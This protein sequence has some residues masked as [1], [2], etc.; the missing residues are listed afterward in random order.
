MITGKDKGKT[1]KIS[2]AFP[3]KNLVL[4]AGVNVKKR[5]QKARRS[6]Q[7]GQVL[8][9]ASPIHI[10]NVMIVEE[11]KRGRVGMRLAGEKYQRFHKKTGRTI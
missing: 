8:D 5:H 7:K 6:G 1:G 2:R 11:G 3:K 4:I 10:S 9:L